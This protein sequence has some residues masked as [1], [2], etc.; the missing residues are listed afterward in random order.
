[1]LGNPAFYGRYGYRRDLAEGF[2]SV[3]QGDALQAL[4]LGDFPR[5]GRLRYAR[6]FEGL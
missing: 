5:Q 2:Q 3:W 4:A 6:A 1:V